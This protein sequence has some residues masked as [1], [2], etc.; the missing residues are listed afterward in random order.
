MIGRPRRSLRKFRKDGPAWGTFNLLRRPQAGSSLQFPAIQIADILAG[1]ART[2]AP[3]DN[4]AHANLARK[5][6]PGV[7]DTSM[8]PDLDWVDL[9]RP[10]VW[11]HV[12]LLKEMAR[13]ARAGED[14]MPGLREFCLSN[15]RAVSGGARASRRRH[16]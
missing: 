2:I 9:K 7:S 16:R 3:R 15:A 8:L 14:A 1:A 11:V 10:S 5:L 4:P 6:A 13:R 12:A